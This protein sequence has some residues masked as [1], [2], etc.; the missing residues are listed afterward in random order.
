MKKITLFL[1]VFLV[2]STL[3]AQK[4]ISFQGIARDAQGNAITNQSISV[5]FTIGTFSETQN[6]NTDEFGVFSATI[7]SENSS[8][9]DKLVFANNDDNLKVEIDGET[10]Y[11]DKFNTVPY[12][13]AAD[14]GVPVGAIMPFAGA[15]SSGG[16]LEEPINGW[17]VCNGATLTNN[18]KFDKLKSVLGSAWGAN[19]V[20]DLR[21]TFLRG[22]NNGRSDTYKD[23]DASSRVSVHSGNSGDKVGAF[24]KDEFKSHNHEITDP[25]HKHEFTYKRPQ[26]HNEFD[27]GNDQRPVDHY[28]DETKDTKKAYTGITIN[29]R[30]GAETRPVNA[31]VN[32]IIK[33]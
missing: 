11:N 1:L 20:P 5:K 18:A 3:F 16:G 15:V 7:G 23:P 24:Q 9:F 25:G 10:I 26:S 28:D 32:F 31:A 30:G 27:W 8:D 21:G 19:R 29:N 14:N 6:L 4:G 12:A 13:K 17:I 33:Y 22:V 2:S